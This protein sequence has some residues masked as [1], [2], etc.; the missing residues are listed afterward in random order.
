MKKNITAHSGATG[1][2]ERALGYTMNANPGPGEE[3]Y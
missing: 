2:R 1:I 3:E